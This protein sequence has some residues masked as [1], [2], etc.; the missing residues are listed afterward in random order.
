MTECTSSLLP[1]RLADRQEAIVRPVLAVS[2]PI[3]DEADLGPFLIRLLRLPIEHTDQRFP[4]GF[5]GL[6]HRCAE[7][8]GYVSAYRKIDDTEPWVLALSAISPYRE[9]YQFA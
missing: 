1:Q 2:R 5:F 3:R 7:R 6:Q 8:L 4:L 9:P